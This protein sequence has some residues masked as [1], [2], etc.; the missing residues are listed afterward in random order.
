M[1]IK[2]REGKK[3]KRPYMALTNNEYNI[4]TIVK[5]QLRGISNDT[6]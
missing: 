1:K 4:Q 3:K 2:E 6:C 5:Q